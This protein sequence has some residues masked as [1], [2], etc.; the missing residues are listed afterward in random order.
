ME[1]DRLHVETRALDSVPLIRA[2]GE[3]DIH[4]VAELERAVSGALEQGAEIV[5]VDL[6]DISYLDSSGLTVLTDLYKAL[7]AKG[8]E[9]YVVASIE[10][11][12]VRRVLQI[13]RVDNFARVRT[14]LAEVL[15]ELNL[16]R[17]A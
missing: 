4:T 12:A 5:V 10:Q 1:N 15:R 3:I 13:T 8:G 7:S 16:P 2:R 9:L 17:A 6:T 14:S 11:P